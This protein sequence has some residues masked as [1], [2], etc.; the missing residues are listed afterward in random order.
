MYAGYVWL[1]HKRYEAAVFIGPAITFGET[2]VQLEA[3]LLI[4][5]PLIS[6]GEIATVECVTWLRPNQ[7]FVTPTAL[8]QQIAQDIKQIQACLQ[9]LPKKSLQ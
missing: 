6:Q 2:D 5:P 9:A 3:H 8:Q 4:E 1:K 7:K